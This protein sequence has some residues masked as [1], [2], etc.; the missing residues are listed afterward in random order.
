MMFMMLM[1]QRRATSSQTRLLLR[2]AWNFC[3]LLLLASLLV[4]PE[5]TNCPPTV[6]TASSHIERLATGH[7]LNTPASYLRGLAHIERLERQIAE[8]ERIH[9]GTTAH[10][11]TY[12]PH[13]KTAP[14]QN[15][16]NACG[17][18]H[19][20][21]SFIQFPGALCGAHHIKVLKCR[22][23]RSMSFIEFIMGSARAAK[24]TLSGLN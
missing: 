9:R 15:C 4:C 21:R 7:A 5:A 24:P 13:P 3:R 8:A 14:P 18:L 22:K 19:S 12:T 10:R 16:P 6:S 23:I 20:Y 2:H 1:R 17:R 11:T